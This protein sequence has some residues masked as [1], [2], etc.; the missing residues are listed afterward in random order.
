MRGNRAELITNMDVIQAKSTYNMEACFILDNSL[1]TNSHFVNIF[2]RQKYYPF[3]KL[4]DSFKVTVPT[5]SPG[6]FGFA[7]QTND[8][9]LFLNIRDYA[10][11]VFDFTDYRAQVTQ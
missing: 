10:T 9:V 3:K 4:S 5:S 6:C 8:K 1:P 7:L 2:L 11:L